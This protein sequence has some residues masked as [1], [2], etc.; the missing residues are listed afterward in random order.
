MKPADSE[1]LNFEKKLVERIPPGPSYIELISEIYYRGFEIYLVGGTVRDILQGIESNDIDLVTTMPLKSSLPLLRSMFGGKTRSGN[2]RVS[3]NNK[4]GFIRIGGTPASGDPFIDLKNFPVYS[5][6]TKSA[7]FGSDIDLDLKLRDFACNAIYYD[8]I[9]KS[10][11]DPSGRGVEDAKSLNLSVVKDEKVHSPLY[12]SAT[13]V[14]R[15]IKFV[16]RGYECSQETKNLVQEK[17]CPLLQTMELGERVRYLNAQIF[18]KSRTGTRR[19][20]YEKFTN[21]MV[22]LGFE[23]EFDK[24]IRPIEDLLNLEP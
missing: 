3:H 22:K 21:S 5:P 23:S 12:H 10:L 18:N 6:G 2:E 19:A 11:I 13:I 17:F 8:P 1:I 9:N 24:Y 14:I 7:L 16:G 4:T 15:L 20:A